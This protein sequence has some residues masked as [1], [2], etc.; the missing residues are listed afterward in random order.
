MT[1]SAPASAAPNPTPEILLE[2]YKLYVDMADRV[3]TRRIEAS[4]F[5]TSLL[6]GLLALLSVIEGVNVTAVR[7]IILLTVGI[8]GVLLCLVW[9]ANIRSYRQMNS[10]KFRVIHEME[11]YL[12]FPCYDREW[13][14]L[15]QDKAKNSYVRLTRVEQY[16]PLLLL[17]PYLILIGYSLRR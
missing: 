7:D 17:I 3:S 14:I 1:H 11:Q 4:K 10:L 8:L 6:T 13:E 15:K 9:I 12:P 2:Q 5:Y 16:V